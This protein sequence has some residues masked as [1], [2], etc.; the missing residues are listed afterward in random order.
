MIACRW[1]RW[2]WRKPSPGWAAG[3][4]P[5]SQHAVLPRR[6]VHRRGCHSGLPCR[7][8]KVLEHTQTS[9]VA[10]VNGESALTTGHGEVRADKLLVATGRTPNTR[11]PAL[12]RGGS[13]RQCRGAIVI[14]RAC[15][16]AR[17]TFTRPA[18]ARTSHNRLCGGG[19][20]APVPRS[21]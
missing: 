21:T 16:P 3:H 17:H 11:S 1:S 7:R 15:A 9:Q 10:H 14:D 13:H 6:P 18:T 20:T 2:N 5:S 4:D 19:G 12:R 8:I